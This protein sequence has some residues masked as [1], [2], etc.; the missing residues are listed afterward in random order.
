MCE[1]VS[2]DSYLGSKW[3]EDPKTPFD[4]DLEKRRFP[5]MAPFCESML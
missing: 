1:A 2:R 3:M 4:E 5:R